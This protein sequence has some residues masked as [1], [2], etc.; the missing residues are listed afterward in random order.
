MW[1]CLDV[2]SPHESS[3][4]SADGRGGFGTFAYDGFAQL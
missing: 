4:P 3:N 2:I 1:G